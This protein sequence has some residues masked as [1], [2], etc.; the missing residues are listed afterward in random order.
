L[1]PLPHLMI[2][3]IM[4]AVVMEA[5]VVEAEVMMVGAEVHRMRRTGLRLK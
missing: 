2:L 4:E 3:E 5:E 1:D